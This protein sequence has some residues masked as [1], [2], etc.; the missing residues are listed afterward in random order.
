VTPRMKF[1]LTCIATSLCVGLIDSGAIYA[2]PIPE[3][4]AHRIASKLFIAR[5]DPRTRGA[6]P[7]QLRL[8]YQHL[9]P[10]G[11]VGLYVYTPTNAIGFAIVAGDDRLPQLLGYS[12][13]NRFCPD[14][15]PESLQTV[16]ASYMEL[17]RI[18]PSSS[19][20]SA[21]RRTRN[22]QAVPPL[23]E[24]L[25]WGQN[26]PFNLLTPK[27]DGIQTPTGC[28]ATAL[29]QIMR[30]YCW[31]PESI[32]TGEYTINRKNKTSVSI[33]ASYPWPS[34]M[35]SYVEKHGAD[36]ESAVAQLMRNIGF[37]AKMNYSRNES[38]TFSTYAASALIDN[39]QYS[40]SLRLLYRQ[41]HSSDE[42]EQIIQDELQAKRPIYYGGGSPNGGHAFVCDGYD[43]SSLY[44]INWGWGGLSN[45]YYALAELLPTNQGTGAGGDGGYI[46]RQDIIVGIQPK[47][48]VAQQKSLIYAENFRLDHTGTLPRSKV[49][50]A[51]VRAFNYSGKR[52]TGNLG[53]EIVDHNNIPIARFKARNG[54]HNTGIGWGPSDT[55]VPIDIN[56]LTQGTYR[57]FP[58]FYA[59]DLDT[60]ERILLPLDAPQFVT[61]TIGKDGNVTVE[62]DSSAKVQL[63]ATLNSTTLFE[64]QNIIS[65]S[66]TNTGSLPY[67]GLIGFRL[68]SAPDGNPLN[69]NDIHYTNSFIEPGEKVTYEAL[70]GSILDTNTGAKAQFVQ[71]LCDTSDLRFSPSNPLSGKPH[72]VIASFPISVEARMLAKPLCK[73]LTSLPSACQQGEFL[74]CSVNVKLDD[75][76]GYFSGVI[77]LQF[78]QQ[79]GKSLWIKGSLSRAINITIVGSQTITVTF[80]DTISIANGKYLLS[81]G[82]LRYNKNGK[83]T[84]WQTAIPQTN[85]KNEEVERAIEILG[86]PAKSLATL[87]IRV[88]PN[89]ITATDAK[90]TEP[91][92]LRVYP[93]PAHR[94]AHIHF[95]N[96]QPIKWIALYSVNGTCVQR[97]ECSQPETEVSIEVENLPK[98]LYILQANGTENTVSLAKIFIE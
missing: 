23:L 98:G 60:W 32:G 93:N 22:W 3:S 81:V 42:W 11:Q 49:T 74:T 30:Y 57:V 51:V 34:M 64:G 62:N 41:Y 13:S 67:D 54:S 97:F 87:P 70:V 28:V 40:N 47:Y 58:S 63:V 5:T 12:F 73:I 90:H 2:K 71:A 33:A 14:S 88:H 89:L 19:S 4:Q 46:T 79:D 25:E 83:S 44:H 91:V 76:S 75:P 24:N 92:S 52:I 21:P 78:L 35:N 20:N 69:G 29:A 86:T 15:I 17:L 95:T 7:E 80:R 77:A 56:K 66:Y 31:P 43:G 38:S 26:K 9:A 59:S 96:R 39:F 18:S 48:A 36:A 82:I 85:G 53:V 55:I 65:I 68:S 10:N 1:W 37:A 50:T 72:H 94:V 8:E 6:K 84:A 61:L 16:F 45:G 27:V